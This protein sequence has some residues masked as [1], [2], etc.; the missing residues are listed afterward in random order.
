MKTLRPFAEQK[1][2]FL[3]DWAMD[4]AYGDIVEV[5]GR[6]VKP[7]NKFIIEGKEVYAIEDAKAFRDA[8]TS[9]RKDMKRNGNVLIVTNI[10]Q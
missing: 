9:A 2:G 10:G 8:I 4:N 5:G 7:V 6:E 1:I 3:P